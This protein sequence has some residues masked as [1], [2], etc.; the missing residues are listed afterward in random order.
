MSKKKPDKK[1]FSLRFGWG[2]TIALI[3]ALGIVITGRLMRYNP[4]DSEAG[5]IVMEAGPDG[6]LHRVN[7][8]SLPSPNPGVPLQWEV[9]DLIAYSRRLDLTSS[10]LARLDGLKERWMSEKKS[11]LAEMNEELTKAKPHGSKSI[12]KLT[13]DLAGYSRLSELFDDKRD[14]Y[15]R[16]GLAMLT[17]T[18]AKKWAEIQNA[19][20]EER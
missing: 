15:L 1:R 4:S 5:P 14:Y 10:Q 13:S 2:T 8:A 18:Q 6:K 19:G 12:P 9:Q 3:M 11:L 16:L 17:P 7:A 20:K